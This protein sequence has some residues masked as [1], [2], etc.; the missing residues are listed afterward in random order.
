MRKWSQVAGVVAVVLAFAGCSDG[1]SS[2]GGGTTNQRPVAN[3]GQDLTAM[4]NALVILDGRN[5]SDADGDPL[6]YAWSFV[7]QPAG[8]SVV[9]ADAATATPSFTTT[10][11]GS[12]TLQLVVNDGTI[13]SFADTLIVTVPGSVSH[14]RDTGQT[15]CYD[16]QKKINCP[17]YGGTFYG[18]DAQYTTNPLRF[19]V[20]TDTVTDAITGLMWQR[21]DAGNVY[22]W[23]AAMG[24]VD[25]TNNPGGIDVCGSLNLA[26]YSDWRLPSRREYASLLNFVDE[27][28]DLTHFANPGN[29]YWTS[30]GTQADAN[31]AWGVIGSQLT[32]GFG[33][34]GASALRVRCVRGTTW[35]SNSLV[36]NANSTVTDVTTGLIWEKAG[37]SS[38]HNWQEALAYCE[39][40]T[41]GGSSDWR[42]PDIKELESLVD[43]PAS[44]ITPQVPALNYTLFPVAQPTYYWSSTTDNTTPGSVWVVDFAFGGLDRLSKTLNYTFTRCVH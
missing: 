5:S 24:I 36:D 15:S 20:T 16:A 32:Y 41:L 14:L 2:G 33:S 28:A 31:V 4:N 18:Q 34:K 10:H 37:S 43:V 29:S 25:A 30:T 39:G 26:S 22:N 9:L 27:Q 11:Q 12:Y 40:M 21:A 8:S 38:L 17:T 35:G 3:A 19:T 44:D 42:L 6:S 13:D 7:Q 1:A 23:Y